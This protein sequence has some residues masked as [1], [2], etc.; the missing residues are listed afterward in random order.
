MVASKYLP[1]MKTFTIGFDL[2]SASG[3]ELNFDEREKAEHTSYLA[4]TEHYEMVLKA[5]DM[6]NALR[7]MFGI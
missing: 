6:E 5:G 3:L 2:N 7:I 4:Q 1:N